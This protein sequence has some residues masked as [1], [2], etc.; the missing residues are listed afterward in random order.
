MDKTQGSRPAKQQQQGDYEVDNYLD[1]LG[2]AALEQYELTQRDTSS[3]ATGS[4]PPDLFSR[5]LSQPE[6]DQPATDPPFFERPPKEDDRIPSREGRQESPGSPVSFENQEERIKQLEER[7]YERDG[8]VKMLRSELRKRD[9]Q[10]REMHMRLVSEQKAKDERFARETKSLSTQLEFK[11]QEISALQERYSSM[12]QRHKQQQSVVHSSPIPHSRLAQ[13]HAPGEGPTRSGKRQSE[14]LSTETFMPL[15]QMSSS[16]VTPVHVA[17]AP[18]KRGS[19]VHAR[20]GKSVSPEAAGTTQIVASRHSPSLSP[21]L[22]MMKGKSAEEPHT[23]LEPSSAATGKASQPTLSKSQQKTSRSSTPSFRGKT[24]SSSSTAHSHESPLYLHVPPLEMSSRDLLMLLTNGDLLKVPS[25]ENVD[26]GSDMTSDSVKHSGASLTA[27][28]ASLQPSTS[29][30][31]GL[32]S[33]LHI[34]RFS[35][36]S[37]S[38]SSSPL[39]SLSSAAVFSS[40]MTTPVSSSK[41]HF[42]PSNMTPPSAGTSMSIPSLE[43]SSDSLPRTPIRKSKLQL[44]NKPHTCAR[45]DMTR[46]RTRVALDDFPLRKSMSAS[47]TPIR[48]RIS[49][50]DIEAHV[51]NSL[52]SSVN[53]DSLKGS[54]LSLLR[55]DDS[56]K[57]SSML[58]Q[59]DRSHSSS[60]FTSSLYTLSH[61]GAH[62]GFYNRGESLSD[63]SS[64]EIQLLLIVGDIVVRYVTDQMERVRASVLSAASQ[65]SSDLES[66]D[67]QSPK[68]SLG[69]STSS[70]ASSELNQPSKADQS[71]VC[72]SLSVLETLLIYSQQARE[73]LTAPP[74]PE[75]AFEDETPTTLETQLEKVQ[76]ARQREG[77]EEEGMEGTGGEG[78]IRDTPKQS[79]P[80][81]PQV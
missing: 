46:S 1:E 63:S 65:L 51:S 80:A 10:L 23:V 45:T 7:E 76:L 35:S 33:L 36:S 77:E 66:L 21:S 26:N 42:A 48:G 5:D 44:R 9:D 60:Y 24:P 8:E 68:S 32:L 47:N 78:V 29:S 62:R 64:V 40:G 31:P 54:I 49:S 14:F 53:I 73:Q 19:H 6:A 52:V 27:G 22:A 55:A 79:R 15:S 38:S 70:R 30:L 11:D 58:S 72:Q 56:S 43:L 3:A 75:F 57:L 41:H 13:K 20:G 4:L 16:D 39:S 59:I 67:T 69:S 25:F 74:P 18:I 34:P 61:P 71:L 2:T 17:H 50:I 81:K 28:S 37:S 12:E